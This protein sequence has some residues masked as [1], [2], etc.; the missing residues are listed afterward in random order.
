MS[1]WNNIRNWLDKEPDTAQQKSETTEQNLS[2]PQLFEIICLE[3]GMNMQILKKTK[4][5]KLFSEWYDGDGS[6][7]CIIE[8]F[9]KFRLEHPSI[10]NKFGDLKL[11]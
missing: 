5:V 9:K 2:V 6:R 1:L 4:V 11:K 10:D 3:S 8:C 7:E